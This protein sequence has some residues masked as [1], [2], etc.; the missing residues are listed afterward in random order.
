[1][2]GFSAF[3]SGAVYG[4][5]SIIVGHPLDTLKTKM[6]AQNQHLTSNSFQVLI[7]TIKADGLIGLYRG[8]IPPLLGASLLRSVQFGIFETSVDLLKCSK[9]IY[10]AGICSGIARAVIECPLEVAK[11]RRQVGESWRF[12]GLF[13][14]FG[15]NL[16]RNVPLLT[17]FFAFV[18]LSKR[19]DISAQ[20]R[21]FIT[22]SVC[23]TLAWTVVWPFDVVKSR[24]QA[25]SVYKGS[26]YH[27][28]LLQ[29]RTFGIRGFF[30]WLFTRCN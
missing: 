5:T 13:K 8:C 22:G 30:P 23:S 28:F 29:Y 9:T 24:I 20:W 10:L 1:M 26:I 21:P 7:R 15:A 17:L 2:E 6:Q 3:V 4:L 27:V 19:I 18:D 11:I 25:E 14:G 12:G 16:T